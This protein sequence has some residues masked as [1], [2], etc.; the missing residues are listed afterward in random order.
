MAK[1]KELEEIDES[2]TD[3]ARLSSF[4]KSHKDLIL[5]HVDNTN[6]KTSTGSLIFDSHT[7][8]G[9]GPGVIRFAGVYESGKTSAA[10]TV[11][12]NFLQDKNI[13]YKK[14]CLYIDSEA[15]LNDEVRERYPV[16]FTLDP[17]E[18]DEGTV[19]VSKTKYYEAMFGMVKE[20]VQNN[21]ENVKYIIVVDSMDCLISEGDAE[22]GIGDAVKVAGGALLTG[23]FLKQLALE[24]KVYGHIFLPISQARAEVRINQYDPSPKKDNFSGGHAL[25][26]AADWI[27]EFQP[28]NKSNRYTFDGEKVTVDGDPF[29]WHECNVKFHKTK[30]QKTDFQFTYPVKYGVKSGSSV[31][32]GRECWRI[33]LGWDEM[34]RDGNG[35][36][37]TSSFKAELEELGIKVPDKL[38]NEKAAM[39]FFDENPEVVN[40]VVSKFRLLF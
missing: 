36:V 33:L 11:V 21:P 8:G 4:F 10:L 19:L 18:W 3:K 22:K 38:K 32:T 1:V 5:N 6:Y 40:Y 20:I 30:N 34:K 17:A 24:I 13:P 27:C 12:S 39:A 37:F 28:T 35:Y 29:D 31:W 26:H 25:L 2:L 16:K 7:G 15:R 23:I 14:K 9:F